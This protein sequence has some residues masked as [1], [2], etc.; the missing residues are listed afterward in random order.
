MRVL[1]LF[2]ALFLTVPLFISSAQA[3]NIEEDHRAVRILAYQG[4]EPENSDDRYVSLAEFQEHLNLLKKENYNVL[5]LQDVLS[6]YKK[7][8][9]LPPRS[10]VM[11]FD[12]MHRSILT[13]AAPLLKQYQFPYT[14]LLSS[15]SRQVENLNK[16]D[17]KKLKK[18]QLVDFGIA[19]FSG[20]TE[21]TDIRRALNNTQAFY[22]DVFGEKAEIMAFHRG[23][24]SRT[25]LDV[26]KQYDFKV[27][28]GEG[29]SVAYQRQNIWPRFK[30]FKANA[31]VIQFERLLQSY[32][33]PAD[34]VTPVA[35]IVE[36]EHPAIG[37]TAKE[38]LNLDRLSCLASGQE[39]P[40]IDVLGQ[41]VE[42]RLTQTLGDTPVQIKCTLPVKDSDNFDIDRWRVWG[43]KLS[44]D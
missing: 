28:F 9:T 15:P 22:R 12:G 7:G 20:E 25:H 30:I 36:S 26:L 6:A 35:T 24:Y 23:A 38:G 39:S 29:Q 33:L 32:P 14:V 40:Q 41:R 43:M 16:K 37:F 31:D 2:V 10:V 5:A 34:E 8:A 42:L 11:T 3:F 17:I 13:I 27:K 19:P 21:V 4:I 18:Q 1:A 44:K